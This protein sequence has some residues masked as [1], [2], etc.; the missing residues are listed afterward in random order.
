MSRPD[1]LFSVTRYDEYDS[2][3]ALYDERWGGEGVANLLPAYERLVLGG[4]E[5]GSRILDLC[6]GTGHFAAA[7]GERGHEVFGVDGSAEMLRFARRNAP[8]ATFVCADASD[9]NAGTGF[10]LVLSTFD[11]LNHVTE[12]ERLERTF[13]CVHAALR[14]GG[15]FAFDLNTPESFQARWNGSFGDVGDARVYL[16]RTSHDPDANLAEFRLTLF[17]LDPESNAWRRSD[18]TL[19]QRA[20]G[21]DE[22]RSALLG[23]GFAGIDL[24]RDPKTDRLFIVALRG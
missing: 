13:T 16:V 7:L 20:F 24:Q 11:S 17:V 2:F 12:L 15:R 6:C 9:F 1:T 4:L 8:G 23:A 14:P 22:L 19:A 18:L 21:E 3:A 10:D 5:P